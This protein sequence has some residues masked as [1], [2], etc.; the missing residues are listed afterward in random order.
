[1]SIYYINY[2]ERKLESFL[3]EDDVMNKMIKT[4][5]NNPEENR[6]EKD[7]ILNEFRIIY[8]KLR[9][10]LN[11]LKIEEQT[12]QNM[13]KESTNDNLFT[14]YEEKKSKLKKI[15]LNIRSNE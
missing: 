8:F 1:L 9:T 14:G 5:I 11:E 7:K 13:E 12:L 10:E 6:E 3:N 15:N 2:R 4:Q